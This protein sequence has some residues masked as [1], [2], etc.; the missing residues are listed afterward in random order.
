MSGELFDL[1]AYGVK[2]VPAPPAMNTGERLR[3]RQAAK[4]AAGEHPLSGVGDKPSRIPLAP[5]G[6]GTCGTCAH[7]MR[8]AHHGRAYPKCAAEAFRDPAGTG[9]WEVWPR[10][11]HSESTDVRSWWPACITYEPQEAPSA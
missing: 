5:E 1:D 3:A 6:T 4:I 9:F 10:A 8:P 11:A 7:K 2:P